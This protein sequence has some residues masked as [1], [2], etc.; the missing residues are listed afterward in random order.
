V[1][2]SQ[3][4]SPDGLPIICAG[5]HEQLGSNKQILHPLSVSDCGS[6]VALFDELHPTYATH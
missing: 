3:V 5:G 2:H 4:D 6:W 1:V